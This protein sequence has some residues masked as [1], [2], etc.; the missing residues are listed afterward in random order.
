[1]G[2][3]VDEMHLLKLAV[4]DAFQTV[5]FPGDANILSPDC[6]GE[7]D[8]VDETDIE[9]FKCDSDWK[10]DWQKIPKEVIEYN[11]QSLAF[12]SPAAFQFYLPAYLLQAID[13]LDSNVLEFTVY[14]LVPSEA[15]VKRFELRR[16]A[17]NDRQQKVVVRFL[18]FVRK[19]CDGGLARVADDGLNRY[20]CVG[21]PFQIDAKR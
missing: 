20:W 14:E 13:A 16:N 21:A 15:F 17:L 12:F 9:D 1:M 7:P 2:G 5:E 8:C 18:E 19:W 4:K 3:F 11:Y 10:T 6:V